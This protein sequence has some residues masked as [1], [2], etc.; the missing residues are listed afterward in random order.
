M[1]AG[2]RVHVCM[3]GRM[4]QIR[5]NGFAFLLASQQFH[6]ASAAH[7]LPQAVSFASAQTS[8]TA[9]SACHFHRPVHA[10]VGHHKQC[11]QSSRPHL[12]PAPEGE[13]IDEAL[14][15]FASRQ[16]TDGRLWP[17]S[18]TK[19]LDGLCLLQRLSIARARTSTDRDRSERSRR[20]QP[21]AHIHVALPVL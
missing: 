14:Q 1:S 13:V 8:L 20:D 21:I 18:G 17:G 7:Y 15:Q 9:P 2:G 19:C 3:D 16:K 6:T 12:S 10:P 4:L 5:P 11:R